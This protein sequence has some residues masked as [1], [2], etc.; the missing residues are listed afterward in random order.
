MKPG[1]LGSCLNCLYERQTYLPHQGTWASLTVAWDNQTAPTGMQVY[2]YAAHGRAIYTGSTRKRPLCE[3]NQHLVV[4]LPWWLFPVYFTLLGQGSSKM[5]CL[6]IDFTKG[7]S[8]SFLGDIHVPLKVGPMSQ[9]VCYPLIF[10][11][12]GY[13]SFTYTASSYIIFLILKKL[14]PFFVIILKIVSFFSQ[15]TRPDSAWLGMRGKM[16]GACLEEE[17][18]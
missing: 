6:H 18:G 4:Q 13:T 8:N 3:I 9:K 7:Q 16:E 10:W 15:P 12:M 11:G 1:N 2:G 17:M 14:F 5:L